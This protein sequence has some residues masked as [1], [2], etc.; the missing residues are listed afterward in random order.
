MGGRPVSPADTTKGLHIRC[1]ATCITHGSAERR[2]DGLLDCIRQGQAE[3][4]IKLH[5]GP[6][7]LRPHSLSLCPR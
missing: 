7:C 2:Y 4:L 5:K 3:N 1:V 6:A